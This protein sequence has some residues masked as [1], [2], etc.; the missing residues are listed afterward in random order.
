MDN[1][2]FSWSLFHRMPIV[3][4]VR[5]LTMEEIIQIL[6]L[7]ADAGLTTIEITMNTP[8]AEEMI[9]YARTNHGSALNIG[10]GTVCNKEDLKKAVASGA[11]FIVT[12]ILQKKLIQYCVKRE[13]PIFPGAFTPSEIYKA[14]LWGAPMIKLFPAKTLGPEY[15]KDIKAPLQEIKLIPTGGIDADNLESFKKAGASGFGIGS[16]LFLKKLIEAK[17]W[18]GLTEHFKKFVQAANLHS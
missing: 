8:G 17:D 10:A 1:K 5:N 7:Y 16:P 6:P 13:M 15:V 18:A 11:Q 12:P 9:R 3:G 14:W 4:I 2:K